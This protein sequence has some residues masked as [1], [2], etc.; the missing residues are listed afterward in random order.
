MRRRRLRRDRNRC[1][2]RRRAVRGRQRRVSQR[3]ERPQRREVRRRR[4]AT[5]LAVEG[6][7][8]GCGWN[9]ASWARGCDVPRRAGGRMD[10]LRFITESYE[11]LRFTNTPTE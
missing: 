6:F 1:R 5:G 9:L 11:Y 3:W 8:G 7:R 10:R 4:E 2:N